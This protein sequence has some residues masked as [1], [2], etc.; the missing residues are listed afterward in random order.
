MDASQQQELLQAMFEPEDIEWRVQR[1]GFFGDKPWVM[2][3]PYITARAV[4]ERFDDVFGAF[5][6]EPAF[7]DIV[8]EGRIIG[9]QCGITVH[10]EARSITKWDASENTN[11]TNIDA[12]KSGRSTSMKRAAVQWGVG[13]YLYQMDTTF[14]ECRQALSFRD[15]VMGNIHVVKSKGKPDMYIDWRTPNLPHWAIPRRN[16]SVYFDDIRAATDMDQLSMALSEA[17]KAI[18]ASQDM[19]AKAEL[20]IL[21][22][23]KIEELESKD[24]ERQEQKTRELMAKSL[25]LSALLRNIPTKGALFNAFEKGV[26]QLT[27]QGKKDGISSVGAIE[28]LRETYKSL[29]HRMDEGNSHDQ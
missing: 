25:D 12:I 8:S 24:S 4:Q 3:V 14:A 27:N 17:I 18:K 26:L 28:T 5:G 22:A 1:A 13:R 21:R 29:K 23:E 9:C 10:T 7:R 15:K 2:A 20:Q 11:N 19:E 16:F 6:W